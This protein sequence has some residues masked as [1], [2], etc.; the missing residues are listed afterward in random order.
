MCFFIFAW[1]NGLDPL[2]A[3]S[4]GEV[5]SIP[6]PAGPWTSPHMS[7]LRPPRLPRAAALHCLTADQ[8]RSLGP[9]L[10]LQPDPTHPT[11]RIPAPVPERAWALCWGLSQ[12]REVGGWGQTEG[13]CNVLS[14]KSL[15]LEARRNSA[16]ILVFLSP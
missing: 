13:E 9:G 15:Q 6:T 7:G 11:N 1:G 3:S 4:L 10:A 8:D 16:I 14:Q 5:P 12:Q 2:P